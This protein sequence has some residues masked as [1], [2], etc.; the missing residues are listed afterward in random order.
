[1]KLLSL[2]ETNDPDTVK[3]LAWQDTVKK[4]YPKLASKLKFKARVEGGKDLMYA[5][6]PGEDRCYGVFDMTTLKGEVL[7]D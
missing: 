7:G 2:I 3:M 4:A 5:E 6:V 1:M